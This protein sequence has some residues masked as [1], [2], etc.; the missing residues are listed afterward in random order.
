MLCYCMEERA[1]CY[2]LEDII[3][4][5]VFVDMRFGLATLLGSHGSTNSLPSSH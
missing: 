3:R 5:L 2:G 1:R 4:L